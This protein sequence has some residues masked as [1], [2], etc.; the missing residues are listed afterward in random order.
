LPTKNDSECVVGG[1]GDWCSEDIALLFKAAAKFPGGVVD[2]WQVIARYMSDHTETP[3]TWQEC[4]G[5]YGKGSGVQ[6]IGGGLQVGAA[7]GWHSTGLKE[8]GDLGS[9]RDYGE[10]D[11]TRE[12]NV[13]NVVEEIEVEWTD[14]RLEQLSKALKSFPPSSYKDDPSR[15]AFCSIF[16]LLKALD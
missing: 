7:S 16:C 11:G 6:A 4:I 12:A 10:H 3:R 15:Q 9:Y 14:L 13:I 8:A 1:N 5:T 2:R